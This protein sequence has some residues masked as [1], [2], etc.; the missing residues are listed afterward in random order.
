MKHIMKHPT[1]LGAT[2]NTNG[3]LII[4]NPH[5]GCPHCGT[6]NTKTSTDQKTVLHHPGIECCKT[7]LTQE[8]TWRQS[9]RE[10]L[11]RELQQDEQNDTLLREL[12]QH[13]DTRAKQQATQYKS[14]QYTKNLQR[15]KTEHYQ[16]K[17][18]ELT[19]EITRLTTKRD[20][21]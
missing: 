7:R 19:Q 14:D 21:S 1:D 15:R 17:I 5:L 20:S 16:P 3:Q 4:G 9:E 12:Q 18:R 13:A 10:T 8:I 6:V 2:R 11:N